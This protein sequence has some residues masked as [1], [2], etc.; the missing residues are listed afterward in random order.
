MTWIGLASSVAL[1]GAAVCSVITFILICTLPSSYSNFE[2]HA[3]TE[4]VFSEESRQDSGKSGYASCQKHKDA[5]RSLTADVSVQI[6]VLGDIGRSPRMQYHALSIAKHGGKV[7]IIGYMGA[8]VHPDILRSAFIDIV[9][10]KPF[11]SALQTSNKLLFLLV[12]PL[13]VLYQVCGLYY[14]LAYRTKASKWMLIQNPPSVPTLAICQAMC[15][16]RN[17]RLVIDW[18]NFGYSILALRLGSKHPLVRISKWYEGFFSAHGVH[19]HFCVTNVMA[20]VLKDKWGV[21]NALPLH[22]RPAEIYQP[23]SIEQRAEVLRRL[24]G[25]SEHANDI[26]DGRCK[27]LVSSTSWTPDEDFSILLDALVQYSAA[28]SVDNSLPNIIA[29][30]TGKGPQR[31][32]YLRKIEALTRHGKLPFVMVATA[33]LSPEDYA[34]LLGA[35][36]LGVSLHTSSSGVDLPMKVV[37]MFGTGLPVVG[38]SDFE[39][40]PE[41]VKEGVN[42]KGFDSAEKLVTILRDLFSDDGSGLM[43]LEELRRGAVKEVQRRWED[44]W[45]PVAGKLFQLH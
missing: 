3:V 36:D 21:E 34:A 10:L 22:D 29:I 7:D 9:P 12:A 19:A 11:P 33:W 20:R 40:W 6:V 42:G 45:M 5:G 1:Y 13:K 4:D 18:H 2:P 43:E 31:E 16:L 30:I 44:E 39:A 8:E 23:L 35:A 37:D 27:L 15:F 32:H 26:L 38:W 28:V 14:T 17:T 25:T 41:L 24:P